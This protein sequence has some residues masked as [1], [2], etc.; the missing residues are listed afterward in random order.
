MYIGPGA[1]LYGDIEIAD[2]CYVGA[3]A[4]VNKSFVE[5][6]SVIVGMP[7]KVIKIETKAWNE[8]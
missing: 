4:V 3:N 7:A 8:K 5:P 6:Y 1:V 2:N